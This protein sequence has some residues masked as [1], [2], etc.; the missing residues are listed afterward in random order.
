M[1]QRKIKI[2]IKWVLIVMLA[3]IIA[4]VSSRL[5][6]GYINELL[7]SN[8]QYQL[9]ESESSYTVFANCIMFSNILIEIFLI[10]ICGKMKK[11]C[12]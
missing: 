3:I 9:F 11:K 1:N 4:F 10:Y 2:S 8:W 6:V 12:I 7:R 5:F